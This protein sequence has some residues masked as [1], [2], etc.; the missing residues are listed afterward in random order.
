MPE[1]PQKG[2]PV[3]SFFT[4]WRW[5][6]ATLGAA[7][8]V[9]GVFYTIQ[10]NVTDFQASIVLPTPPAFDGTALPLEKA[11]KWTEL[12]SA[13]WD[14]SYDA[15][16]VS[17]MQLLPVYDPD[18][19]K[20]STEQLGWTDAGDLAIRNAK[21]TYSVPYMGNYLLDGVEYSGSHLAVDIKVPMHTPVYAIANGVVTK[22]STQ[23]TGFGHHIVIRHDSVPSFTGSGTESYFSSYS[24]MSQILVAEGD[25]VER[26]QLIGKTGDTGT[27][28]TPHLHFQIDKNSAPWHPYWPFTFQEASD[29]GLNF[30]SAINTGF[31]QAQAIEATI[32]PMLFVQH[33]LGSV[34]TAPPPDD[35]PTATPP[36]SDP[37]ELPPEVDSPTDDDPLEEPATAPE[38]E[39]PAV[40]FEV[41]HD[42]FFTKGVNQTITIQAVDENGEI[43]T[44][45]K[46]LS[47][48]DIE[49]LLGGADLPDSISAVGVVDGIAKFTITPTSDVGLRLF[50]TD[51]NIS[52]ESEI[53][54]SVMFHDVDRG[55]E[56]FKAISFLKEHDVISGYPDGTFRPD[57]VVSRVEAL[58]F[59][60]NG[61]NSDLLSTTELPFPDT[62]AREWYAGF[63]ATA[64][65]RSIVAGY[66]DNL[67]RPANTV[68]K[69]EF[70]KML[71]LAMD[72]DLGTIVSRDVYEDVPRGAWFARY[73]DFAKDKNL[74]SVDGGNFYPEAGMTRGDVA[75]LMYRLIVLKVSGEDSFS[76]EI[77]VGDA[78]VRRFFN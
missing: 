43:V 11:P 70:L 46:P 31:H 54:Q 3:S 30:T 75:E 29:A 25:I 33:H 57:A 72:V 52:G 62:S 7:F 12:S 49:L 17:K 8:V 5:T 39:N 45:Y 2:E 47:E 9:A 21:I 6:L 76:S 73:V 10:S 64:F 40:K 28:T 66:P 74:I 78:D 37:S 24:H 38:P 18:Q 58:K 27:A 44:D 1:N 65:D 67:F 42:Q 26:G 14:A 61:I 53:M 41:E 15:I 23:S 51:G 19:L 35:T 34:S 50:V 16:P 13:E 63:V 60:L 59:I 68:N 48:I 71:L 77:R 69:A 55:D 4:K 22:A 32:N 56:H 36:S 20:T